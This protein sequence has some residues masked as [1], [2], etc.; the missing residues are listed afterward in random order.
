MNWIFEGY[1][2]E[3][4]II[5]PLSKS[6]DFTPGRYISLQAELDRR[7]AGSYTPKEA[8]HKDEVPGPTFLRA[9]FAPWRL[10]DLEQSC[11]EMHG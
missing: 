5:L 1:W 3:C 10:Q 9:V 6:E 8:A 7:R 11:G 2:R 4:P